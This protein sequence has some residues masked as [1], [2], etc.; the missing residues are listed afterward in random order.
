M[1]ESFTSRPMRVMK[2][3]TYTIER[4]GLRVYFCQI[5]AKGGRSPSV[6]FTQLLFQRLLSYAGRSAE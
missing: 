3:T 5:M 4:E 1:S 6:R 2:E